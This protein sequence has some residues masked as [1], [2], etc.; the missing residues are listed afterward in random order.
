MDIVASV[1]YQLHQVRIQR[2]TIVEIVLFREFDGMVTDAVV[3]PDDRLPTVS[4]YHKA[5]TVDPLIH[6]QGAEVLPL[7]ASVEV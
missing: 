5:L 4:T 3:S 2:D 1:M 7:I 6:E